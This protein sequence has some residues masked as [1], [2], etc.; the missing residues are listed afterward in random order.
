MIGGPDSV[1]LTAQGLLRDVR[2]TLDRIAGVNGD[3]F[4]PLRDLAIAG[5]FVDHPAHQPAPVWAIPHLS[6]GT[7]WLIRSDL[8]AAAKQDL[9]STFDD[10]R[11]FAKAAT[12]PS[13]KRYGWG[14]ALPLGD[15]ADNF[16]Q[17]CLLAE[18]ATLFDGAGYRVEL[19]PPDAVPGLANLAALYRAEDGSPLAPPDIVGATPDDVA[20][21]LAE[22]RI[23]QT[24]D[25]GGLYA[26]IVADNPSLMTKLRS[27]P[28]PV[29]SKGWV[30]TATT[31]T[32]VVF[33][34]RANSELAVRL[35]EA[36]LQPKRFEQVVAAG[37]GA[38]VPPY[39][40]LMRVPFW[41]QDPNYKAYVMGARGDP[42][43][44][45][46]FATLGQP[47]PL[48]LPVAV[49]RAGRLLVAAARSVA[50][51]AQD[52][53][54][55]AQ[56]LRDQVQSLVGAAYALQPAPTPT[57]V[58]NWYHLLEMVQRNLK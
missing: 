56:A 20:G 51:G 55:V 7:A 22:G 48:T 45:F 57:P 17:A 50:S 18:G 36:L 29:G 2:E 11:A 10:A 8:L 30:T 37:R 52:P 14:G 16:V 19:N 43:Q 27:L 40:Y 15:A 25:F 26:R 5:P 9:P 35:V 3:L 42:A 1:P 38:V 4:P 34:R 21:A 54:A 12:D 33:D 28:Y 41:D 23:A 47:A 13:A 32:I 39:A 44:N 46:Q 53:L 49:A 6:L 24:I 58:P 31:T